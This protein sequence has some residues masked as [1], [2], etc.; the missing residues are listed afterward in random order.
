[1]KKTTIQLRCALTGLMALV[2]I[3]SAQAE[4]GVAISGVVEAELGFVNVDQGAPGAAAYDESGVSLATVELHIDGEITSNVT[5]H[6]SLLFE[7]GDTP[8][9]VDEGFITYGDKDSWYLSVGQMYV[10]FGS[11]DSNMISDPVT[12]ELGETRESAALVGI[13]FGDLNGRFYIFNGTSIDG[14]D[15]SGT[16]TIE[17]MGASLTYTG[18]SFG[19]GADYISSLGDSDTLQGL[20]ASRVKSYIPG[21]SISGFIHFGWFSF[22]MENISALKSFQITDFDLDGDLDDSTLAYTLNK[23]KPMA[24][25]IEVGME[26]GNG[27]LG[28]A[29]QNTSNAAQLGLPETRILAAYIMDL[30]DGVSLGFEFANQEDYPVSKGGTGDVTTAVTV[31]LAAEF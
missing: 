9:E 25:N 13:S 23:A 7:E 2:S 31:Q 26:L 5:A 1:M 19:V 28:I 12:L 30:E 11:F 16:D 18:E 3:G 14:T 24:N 20:L 22:M 27:T 8:L 10:P 15:I 6:T 17:H 21:V 29:L 4:S